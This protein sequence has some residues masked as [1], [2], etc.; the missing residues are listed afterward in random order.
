ML[1]ERERFRPP[2]QAA[3]LLLLALITASGARAA[4]NWGDAPADLTISEYLDLNFKLAWTRHASD[5]PNSYSLVSFYPSSNPARALV[6]VIQT[7]HDERLKPEDLRREIRNFGDGLSSEF[8]SMARHPNIAKR[9][10]ITNPKANFVVRH[11]RLSD[12][13]ETLGVTINGQTVFDE[14]EIANAAAEVT[15]RGAI[16]SW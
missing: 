9:W 10:T 13:R 14:K 3:A 2:K 15:A 12:L 11:V 7:W 4:D 8:E 16:W 1:R 5:A 6:V